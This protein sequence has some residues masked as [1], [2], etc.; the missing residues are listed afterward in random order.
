MPQTTIECTVQANQKKVWELLNNPMELGKCI[1]GC[2][3]VTVVN[4]NDSK[5]KI[6]IVVGVISRRIETKV[7]YV[8]REEPRKLIINVDSTEGEITASLNIKLTSENESTVHLKVDANIDARGSFQWIVN[9][10]IKSQLSKY[11][12]EF[13]QSVSQKLK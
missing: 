10:V 6:K 4:E 13:V 8:Q 1:P 9:Q 3:E 12:N 7:R 11:T 5:W 2:E